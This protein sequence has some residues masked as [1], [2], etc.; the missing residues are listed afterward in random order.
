MSTVEHYSFSP[1]I[2]TQLNCIFIKDKLQANVFY[3]YNG[4]LQ[5][6]YIDFEDDIQSVLQAGYH[7]LDASVTW[8]LLKHKQLSFTVGAKNILNVT[9]VNILG[10]N[11]TTAHS[12]SS[13]INAGR[14]ASMFVS[15]R[16]KFNFN[17]SKL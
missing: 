15:A 10:Q 14:G 12:T 9:Q 3:K 4:K 16:Y 13:N 5:S 7:I 17:K 1:E 8:N 2:G 6:F 11:Q